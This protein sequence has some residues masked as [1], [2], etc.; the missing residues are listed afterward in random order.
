MQINPNLKL[1]KIFNGMTE[2]KMILGDEKTVLVFDKHR[3]IMKGY[4]N[5]CGGKL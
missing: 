2:D 1:L 3:Q 4:I 5:F